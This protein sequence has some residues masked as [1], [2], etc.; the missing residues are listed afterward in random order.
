MI[1]IINTTHCSN[2]TRCTERYKLQAEVGGQPCHY[3]QARHHPLLQDYE[4]I[5]LIG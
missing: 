4:L 1:V 2:I 5:E 3:I